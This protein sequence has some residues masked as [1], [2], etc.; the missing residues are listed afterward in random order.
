MTVKE[1]LTLHPGAVFDLLTEYGYI[2]QLGQAGLKNGQ[3]HTLLTDSG[4]T[5]PLENVL[6]QNVI[7]VEQ[8][9]G[10]TLIYTGQHEREVVYQD[11]PAFVQAM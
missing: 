6:K 3:K 4:E 11:Q 1:F 2:S 8:Q 5:V 9:D 10:S 7:D